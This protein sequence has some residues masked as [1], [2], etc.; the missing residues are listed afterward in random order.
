M[1][2]LQF[3]GLALR[4][5][6]NVFKNVKDPNVKNT[7]LANNLTMDK[8]LTIDIISAGYS[9]FVFWYI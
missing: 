3:L 8:F 4:L 5:I 9:A 7:E 6:F 2:A 1:S